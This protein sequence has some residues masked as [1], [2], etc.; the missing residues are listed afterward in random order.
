MNERRYDRLANTFMLFAVASALLFDPSSSWHL[1]VGG[2]GIAAGV[3]AVVLYFTN[4]FR[5]PSEH[6]MA[7]IGK[8][9]TASPSPLSATLGENWVMG[10]E[11]DLKEYYA[12]HAYPRETSKITRI[13]G[14]RWRL[15][16][17]AKHAHFLYGDTDEDRAQRPHQEVYLSPNDIAACAIEIIRN[18]SSGDEYDRWQFSFGPEGLHVS[19]KNQQDRTKASQ[20]DLDLGQASTMIN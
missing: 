16:Q 15:V 7:E 20:I 1:I 18:L 3:S 19:A 5:N 14:H 13:Y 11:A 10:I 12:F 4:Q 8:K 17:Q 2:V 6:A 9:P